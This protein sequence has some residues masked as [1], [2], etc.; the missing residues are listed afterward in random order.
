MGQWDDAVKAI[1]SRTNA[2]E[3][4]RLL[5]DARSCAATSHIVRRLVALSQLPIAVGGRVAIVIGARSYDTAAATRIQTRDGQAVLE[6][7][8]F[9]NWKDAERWLESHEQHAGGLA[10]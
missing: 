3:S 8:V 6:L 5:I 10:Q 7:Q 1:L 4:M 2:V 9:R